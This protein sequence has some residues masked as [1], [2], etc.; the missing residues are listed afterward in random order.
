MEKAQS[1]IQELNFLM[2][3]DRLQKDVDRELRDVM[4]DNKLPKTDY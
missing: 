2:D 1:L 4:R 3:M